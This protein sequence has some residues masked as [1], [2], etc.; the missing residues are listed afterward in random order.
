M[1]CAGREAEVSPGCHDESLFDKER[2]MDGESMD[3]VVEIVG[4]PSDAELD[5]LD[6]EGGRRRG[7]FGGAVGNR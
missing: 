1:R 2:S 6:K 3:D 7:L 4:S 5:P